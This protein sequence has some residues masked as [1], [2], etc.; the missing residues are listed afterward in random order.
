MTS[1]VLPLSTN[2]VT[3]SQKATKFVWRD[4]PLGKSGQLPP[5]TSLFS[6]WLSTVSRRI[7]PRILPGTGVRLTILQLLWSSFYPF[8]GSSFPVS[9]NV[10]GLPWLFMANFPGPFKTLP[11]LLLKLLWSCCLKLMDCK[12]E[13]WVWEVEWYWVQK[14]TDELK[15]WSSCCISGPTRSCSSTWFVRDIIILSS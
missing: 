8:H 2:M 11:Y 3:M 5:I 6:T 10:P 14:V 9:D 1:V 12:P 7:F 4:L 13:N 15:Q